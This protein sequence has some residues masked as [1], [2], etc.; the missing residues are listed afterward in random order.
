M[1]HLYGKIT[2]MEYTFLQLF[3]SIM[4]FIRHTDFLLPLLASQFVATFTEEFTQGAAEMV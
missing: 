3:I 1:S 2:V 4:V